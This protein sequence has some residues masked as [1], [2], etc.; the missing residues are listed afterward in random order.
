MS[1]S[2]TDKDELASYNNAAKKTVD[3]GVADEVAG[4]DQEIVPTEDGKSAQ[5]SEAHPN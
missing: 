2:D 1:G 5:D 3:A 4:Y